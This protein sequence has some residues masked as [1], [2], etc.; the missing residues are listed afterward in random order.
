MS[1][2]T[3]IAP[4]PLSGL[5]SALLGAACC[6]PAHAEL[7]DTIHPYVSVA[8]SYDAN[9]FRLPDSAPAFTGDRSDTSTQ[10][11]A[12]ILFE[13]P[14]GRQKLSGRLEA[15]RVTFAT[16]DELDYNG[17][18]GQADLEW[19]IGNHLSGHAGLTYAQELTSFSD[20]H[21]SERNLRV[22]RRGYANGGWTFHPSWRVRA[23]YNE[24][25]ST[26][27]L[28]SQRFNDR[29]EEDGNVG[30]DYFVASGSLIGLQLG[31]A[32]G[33]YPNHV[34]AGGVPVD[35]SY[36]QNEVKLNVLW[37]FSATSQFQMLAGHARREHTYS[38]ARDSSGVNGT[39]NFNWSML[40][41]LRMNS[42]VWRRYAAV[43]SVA[44]SNS[45]NTGA[46]VSADWE[47]TGKTGAQFSARSEKRDFIPIPGVTVLRDF[48]DR[49]RTVSAG[50]TYQPTRQIQLG[51]NLFNERRSGNA[52]TNYRTHGTSFNASVQ[53]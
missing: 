53:F 28:P 27:S 25:K 4:V 9:L 46:L 41:K 26:Y 30:L 16:N 44:V 48:D 24:Q 12:G 29:T 45:M 47:I 21:V 31:R 20:F 37:V 36:T 5:L 43:E 19:Y 33:R 13:R 51:V 42:S 14:I 7:S 32:K 52:Q 10:Y 3:R 11:R 49:T 8:R 50:L 38:N 40:R 17:K 18:D 2:L 15:S 34:L 6:A 35:D 22:Q 23:G 1:S 39:A